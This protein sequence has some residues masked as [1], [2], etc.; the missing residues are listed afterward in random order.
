M[1][2]C[3]RLPDDASTAQHERPDVTDLIAAGHDRDAPLSWALPDGPE[4]TVGRSNPLPNSNSSRPPA[5]RSS[6]QSPQA[7]RANNRAHAPSDDVVAAVD[8]FAHGAHPFT[9]LAAYTGRLV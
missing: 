5:A 3:R 6:A 2:A 4:P 8:E 7:T 1:I 9:R